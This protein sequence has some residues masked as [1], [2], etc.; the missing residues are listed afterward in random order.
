MPVSVVVLEA[1]PSSVRR[2]AVSCTVRSSMFVFF[3][4][5]NVVIWNQ[6]MLYVFFGTSSAFYESKFQNI[7]MDSPPIHDFTSI[8][9]LIPLMVYSNE[10]GSFICVNP[11][12]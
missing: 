12:I 8:L 10:Y 11:S 6:S 2:C 5:N 3:N 1:A 4:N 9:F 7:H